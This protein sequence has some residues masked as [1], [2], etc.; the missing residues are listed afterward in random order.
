MGWWFIQ[1]AIPTLFLQNAV[2]E[3]VPYIW[4]ARILMAAIAIILMLMVKK[5]WE[6]N[7]NEV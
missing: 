3:N 1:S 2:P 5:A 6:N 4:G 7:H